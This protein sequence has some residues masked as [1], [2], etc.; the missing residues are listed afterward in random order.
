MQR[1]NLP[2]PHIRWLNE[3]SGTDSD[4]RYGC[5]ER[6]R[7]RQANYDPP[8]IGMTW[9]YTEGPGRSPIVASVTG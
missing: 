7:Q 1:P 4:E 2:L 5:A 3:V 9:R 6:E 8:L